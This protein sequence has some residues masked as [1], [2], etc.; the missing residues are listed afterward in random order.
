M[1]PRLFGCVTT[2][3]DNILV[4][5][6]P[7]VSKKGCVHTY[8][9]GE[10]DID[11]VSTPL[12]AP[13][14]HT[15]DGFGISCKLYSVSPTELLLLVG[16]HRKVEQ[17]VSTGAA[18][19]YSSKDLGN[20]WEFVQ[21][22]A[23]C[24]SIHKSFFGCSVDINS[25]TAVVGAY[26]DNTEGWRVGSVSIFS[27][28]ELGKWECVRTL[29]PGSFSN[30]GGVSVRPTCSYFG[31]SVALSDSFIA[32]WFTIGKNTGFSIPFSYTRQLGLYYII[33]LY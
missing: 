29:L 32:S 27:K 4:V 28:T 2:M 14:G 8:T 18:Y 20:S 30:N 15:D 7:S 1:S 9:L 12:Y 21:Q 31:F 23:P 6:T 24:S 22:L 3:V 11:E 13:N 19:I 10:R 17:S 5:G 26:G 16:A 25:N 33:T